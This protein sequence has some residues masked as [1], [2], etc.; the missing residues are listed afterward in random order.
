MS[1]VVHNLCK[2][3]GSS[4]AVDC[5]DFEVAPGEIVGLIGPNGAGKTTLL[6][7]LATFLRPTTGSIRVAGFDCVTQSREVRKRI[8]YLP[9]SL[10][11]Y[12]EARVDEYLS[13]RSQLKGIPRRNRATEIDRCLAACDIADVRKRLLGR[14]SQ[15]YRRRVGLADVL[16]GSPLVLLLDEPTI[17][18]DPLQVRHVRDLLTDLARERTILLSTHLLAE[19][20]M[21]CGRALMLLNGRLADDVRVTDVR[22]SGRSLE[23]HFVRVALQPR[24]EAA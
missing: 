9:E 7:M 10:P 15:G 20:E 3:F 8:G 19:A 14:L 23:E 17:G 24:R 6:R 13:F 12:A 21:L 16:L 2:N 4:R 1:I 5:I 11:G 18:L 22:R